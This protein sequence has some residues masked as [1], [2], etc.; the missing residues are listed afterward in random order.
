MCM[1]VLKKNITT[2]NSFFTVYE[3][4]ENAKKYICTQKPL[5]VGE[6][7]PKTTKLREFSS[8]E[9]GGHGLFLFSAHPFQT[10]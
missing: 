5:Q 1:Y 3:I 7:T 10:H 2:M 8:N 4:L 6:K 9:N